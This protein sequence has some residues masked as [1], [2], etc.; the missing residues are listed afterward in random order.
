MLVKRENTSGS[1]ELITVFRPHSIDEICGHTINKKALKNGL[2]N[3]SLSHNFLFTGP[4]GCGKTTTARIIALSVN[5]ESVKRGT[6]EKPCLVC[7]ACKNIMEGNSIDIIEINVGKSGGKDATDKTM[8]DLSY[9]PMVLRNKVVIFDEAHQLTSAS[10]NLL[11]KEIED[12]FPNVYFIFCTNEPEKLKEALVERLIPMHFGPISLDLILDML[13]N[14]CEYEGQMYNDDVLSYISEISK[15]VPRKAISLLKKVMDEGSWEIKNVKEFLVFEHVDEDNPMILDICKELSKGS[16]KGALDV[17]KKMKT[18]SE[19]QVRIA[20]AGTFTNRLS[21]AKTF[22]Q[23]EVFSKILDVVTVP[24]YQTGK[25]AR[26]IL[27]NY[28]FKVSKIIK[29]K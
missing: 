15:G 19:E 24:I 18:V 12:G 7:N 11:F 20:I 1:N 27:T 25:P 2:K 22:E 14:I 9:A 5:C 3:N 13:K 6:V 26:H 28:F 23:G 10:Q 16:F 8:K 29:G 17:L 4:P 21:R